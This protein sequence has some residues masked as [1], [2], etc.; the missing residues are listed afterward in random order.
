M[1]RP[2]EIARDEQAMTTLV[3]LTSSFEGIASM[4]IA[5][6]K[7]QVIQSTNF[8]NTL[9]GIYSQI[10]VDTPFQFGRGSAGAHVI[11]K[12]LYIIITAEGGF[13]GDID[14][15]LV[16][17]MLQSYDPAKM[18]IIVVGGHGATQLAQREIPYK[19]Y[20]KMPSKDRNI[21]VTPIIQQV[22]QYRSTTIFYQEYKSLMVQEVKNIELSTAVKERGDS[23]ERAEDTINE[24]TYI[25]EPSAYAVAAHLERSMMQIAI[26]QLILES[27][28]AQY[29]SRFRA[30]SVSHER[31]DDMKKELHL[32]YNK[33]RR[34]VKDERLKEIINGLKKS[35]AGARA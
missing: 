11:D 25:F 29:A 22:Q 17:F 7:N 28:L 15:K 23:S 6:I 30:M 3:Q 1:R 18:D 14:Q 34:G 33:A 5:Q 35:K 27:K 13:S 9:W 31:A 12:D 26:S 16:E 4:R 19:K 10:H 2:Q 32:A 24:R 8:F 21:N 20:F